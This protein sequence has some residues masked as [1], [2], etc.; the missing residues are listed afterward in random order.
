MKRI[1]F[2]ETNILME[3][4]N[5]SNDNGGIGLFYFF[6]WSGTGPTFTGSNKWPL[7]PDLVADV[8]G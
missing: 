6:G 3:R 4:L 8:H 1:F 2:S 7:I 5:M